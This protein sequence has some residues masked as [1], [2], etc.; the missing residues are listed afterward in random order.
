MRFWALFCDLTGRPHFPP[1]EEGVPAWPSFFRAG[2]SFKIYVAHLG[3]ASLLLGVS[4]TWKSKAVLTAG[5]GLAKPGDRPRS[6][7]PAVSKDQP[8]QLV[9][10]NGW[11]NELSAI[12]LLCWTSLLRAPSEYLPSYGQRAGEAQSSDDRIARKAAIGPSGGKL[13]I[14]LNR[15]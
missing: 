1:R 7:S 13:A 5:R 6:R 15:R 2:S 4:T 11:R 10:T 3:K 14:K 8:T 12:A 9:S